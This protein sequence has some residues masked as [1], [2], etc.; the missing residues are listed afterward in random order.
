MSDPYQKASPNDPILADTWNQMQRDIRDH[1]LRHD[2]TG[3]SDAGTVLN[4]ASIDK[5]S[6]LT[7]EKV[8]AMSA[9]SVNGV[10][11][12][13]RLKG[14]ASE[15][16]SLTGGTVS[17]ALTLG[18]A[19]TVDTDA[20]VAKTLGVTGSVGGTLSVTG[21]ATLKGTLSVTGDASAQS[22]ALPKDAT[23]KFADNGEIRS[24]NGD[25]RI[26]F[27]RSEDILELREFGK[28]ILSAGATKGEATN[29]V[30]VGTDGLKIGSNYAVAAPGQAIRIVW[31]FVNEGA[32]VES[33]KGF[34]VAK[35]SV[36]GGVKEGEYRVTF[37]QP[38]TERPCVMANVHIDGSP[39]D[40][41]ILLAI[42]KNSCVIRTGDSAG[43]YK[44]RHFCFVAIGP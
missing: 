35:H 14:L 15:K 2:H 10:D 29:T 28:I 38:F 40:G 32:G 37:T 36:Q 16:L 30:V 3:G 18:G 43:K 13:E 11:V 1:I 23:I 19:L 22:L 31:G 6:T 34:T 21:N 42:D 5:G 33:G 9:L 39:L 25:H 24:L 8:V 12:G 44:W 17:G 27:R 4:G 41:A 20:K 7:V 26:L